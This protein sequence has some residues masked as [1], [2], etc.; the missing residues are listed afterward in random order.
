MPRMS[1]RERISEG[2]FLLDGAMGTQLI[3]RG[4]EAGVCNDYLNIESPD[5]IFEIHQAYFQAG[6]DAVLTN[7]F[8]ANKFAL[9]T[10]RPR[11]QSQRDKYG[12]GENSPAGS[13]EG[14][15]RLR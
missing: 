12:S 1:L 8:G 4:V 15:I 13:R 5:T 7:T 3:A 9:G 11:R 6:S 10:A 2:I 14:K